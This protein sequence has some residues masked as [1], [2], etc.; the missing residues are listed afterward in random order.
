MVG[1]E[2]EFQLRRLAGANGRRAAAAAA[3]EERDAALREVEFLQEQL[4]EMR[5]SVAELRAVVLARRAGEQ[6]C[7]DLYR[8]REILRAQATERDPTT[9]LN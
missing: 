1:A 3:L 6:Q 8:E 4:T 9:L 7:A 5:Q 2:A